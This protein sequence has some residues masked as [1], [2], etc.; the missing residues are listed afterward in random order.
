MRRCQHIYC[1]QCLIEVL[2]DG[3]CHVCAPPARVP[4]RRTPPPV[5]FFRVLCFA[6]LCFALLCFALLCVALRC[7]ALLCCGMRCSRDGRP[8]PARGL[9]Q[10]ARWLAF[11]GVPSAAA[12]GAPLGADR[13]PTDR[14]RPFRAVAVH[15][16]VG[17]AVAALLRLG[18]ACAC[19]LQSVQ[20]ERQRVA[21][22]SEWSLYYELYHGTR[23]TEFDLALV[24]PC[25]PLPPPPSPPLPPSPRLASPRL[26]S[27][28][29]RGRGELNIFSRLMTPDLR[30]E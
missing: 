17:I 28:P 15:A 10:T 21:L 3:W 8:V 23:L 2:R 30:F 4:P 7:V 12:A 24:M 22:A 16:R 29:L 9:A 18:L 6:L 25:D 14:A 11:A 13:G 26:P 5:P 20:S 1:Q 19:L 27:P